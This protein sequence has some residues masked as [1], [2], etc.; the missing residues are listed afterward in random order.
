[1]FGDLGD[2]LVFFEFYFWNLFVIECLFVVA[3]FGR[4]E[5]VSEFEG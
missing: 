3:F 1:M 5:G 2:L 4:G